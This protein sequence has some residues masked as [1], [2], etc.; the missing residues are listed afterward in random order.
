VRPQPLL[1][2]ELGKRRV[3]FPEW[4]IDEEMIEVPPVDD[5][6]LDVDIFV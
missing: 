4:L 1:A 5:A 6:V 3:I 2:L